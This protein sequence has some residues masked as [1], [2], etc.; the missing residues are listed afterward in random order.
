MPN[1]MRRTLN[2]AG[3]PLNTIRFILALFV[4]YV[5]WGS[6]YPAIKILV[7]PPEGV[8]LP[9][10]LAAGIRLSI[11]GSALLAAG[12]VH[13]KVTKGPVR[14][15]TARQFRTALIA[16]LLLSLGSGALV[17]HASQH[18][19][20]GVMA[21][22]MALAPIATTIVSSASTRRAPLPRVFLG[23]LA[24]LAGV[25]LLIGPDSNFTSFGLA[26]AL[27]AALFWAVGS[28]YLIRADAPTQS[29][30][31]AGIGSFVG[32][33][34]LCSY[35][36]L[37]G[38]FSVIEAVRIDQRSWLAL[39][40]LS[41]VSLVG[42]NCYTWLLRHAGSSLT[43]SHAFVNPVVAAVLGIVIADDSASTQVL[44]AAALVG[45]GAFLAGLPE[46]NR[47]RPAPEPAEDPSVKI[48]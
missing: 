41:A 45:T 44:L 43:T 48:R 26:A 3:T 31:T 32:G 20:S 5:V 14:V 47:I 42:L 29:W 8:G 46:S 13:G 35:A 11:A 10:T 22:I 17:A 40:Y 18:V 27:A 19:D 16:G 36:A 7:A 39:I 1:S 33:V 37:A 15:V 25:A 23:L 28:W 34:G 6:T 21:T 9:P 12:Y 24:G 30:V 4:V 38:E 2:P